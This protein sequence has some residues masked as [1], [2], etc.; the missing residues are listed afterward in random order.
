M[1]VKGKKTPEAAPCDDPPEALRR[2]VPRVLTTPIQFIVDPPESNPYEAGMLIVTADPHRVVIHFDGAPGDRF[3]GSW[4]DLRWLLR[5]IGAER[6]EAAKEE[7][8]AKRLEAREE[9]KM[10]AAWRAALRARQVR[11]EL[12][13][14]RTGDF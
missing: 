12:Q 13:R 9:A 11:R 6:A 8:V 7:A 1:A 3:E 10:R 2:F 14:R 4:T 5:R